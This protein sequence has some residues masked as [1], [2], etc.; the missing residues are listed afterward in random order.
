METDASSRP[1]TEPTQGRLMS[2]DALRGFTMF[3][4]IGGDSI[5]HALGETK[6]T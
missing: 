3:W 6:L 2:L 5:G 1:E 4:I